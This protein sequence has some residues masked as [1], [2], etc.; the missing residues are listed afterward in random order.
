MIHNPLSF[1]ELYALDDLMQFTGLF[2]KNGKPIYEGDIVQACF[3]WG[4]IGGIVE[5][6]EDVA[7]FGFNC[8][9]RQLFSDHDPNIWEVL[10]D[11]YENPDLLGAE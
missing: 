11:K 6:F 3:I 4:C 7:A 1:P 2:D 10:G 8:V 5:Y 9:E